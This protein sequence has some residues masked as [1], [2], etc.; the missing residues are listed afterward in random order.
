MLSSNNSN[1]Y[2]NSAGGGGGDDD[3]DAAWRGNNNYR[4]LADD[5][6]SRRI[7]EQGRTTG[8]RRDTDAADAAADVEEKEELDNSNRPRDTS[9]S[10]SSSSSRARMKIFD[11]NGR[12]WSQNRVRKRVS[13][14]QQKQQPPNATYKQYETIP[15]P[16][17]TS[18]IPFNER[19]GLPSPPL[20]STSIPKYY[21]NAYWN[22]QEEDDDKL[23]SSSPSSSSLLPEYDLTT[24][25]T[26]SSSSSSLFA[27]LAV[28]D[29]MSSSSSAI[30]GVLPVSELFYRSQ[31]YENNDGKEEEEE[32]DIEEK[33]TTAATSSK[34]NSN[35]SK[36]DKVESLSSSPSP[37]QPP[38]P[39]ASQFSGDVT[40]LRSGLGIAFNGDNDDTVAS[41]SSSSLSLPQSHLSEAVQRELTNM[42]NQEVEEQRRLDFWMQQQQQQQDG[43]ASKDRFYSSTPTTNNNNKPSNADL[44]KKGSG[45]T[46]PSSEEKGAVV[47]ND[48][49]KK[50]SS[51]SSSSRGRKSSKINLSSNNNNNNKSTYSDPPPP[52][53]HHHNHRTIVEQQ[54]KLV[55][56]G[57]EMLVG[58]EPINADPPQRSIELNYYR[59]HPKLWARA[60]TTNAPD[61][62]PLLH[63]HSA[64][65]V[66]KESIYLY[67]ENFV[68]STM[69]WG[70]CPEDLRVVVSEFE[71]RRRQPKNDGASNNNS[72]T[73]DVEAVELRD[74]LL[75]TTSAVSISDND[76]QALRQTII[77]SSSVSFKANHHHSES[78]K[79]AVASDDDNDDDD[80]GS[81]Y[82]SMTITSRELE[83]PKGFGSEKQYGSTKKWKEGR[84]P[85]HTRV[86]SCSDPSQELSRGDDDDDDDEDDNNN[87]NGRTFTLGGELKFSLGV[88]R[89]EIESDHDIKYD[90]FRRVLRDGINQSIHA[91]TIGFDVRIAELV[92]ED[93]VEEGE[94]VEAKSIDIVV[95]FHLLPREAMIGM[96]D[97]RKAAKKVNDAL[98][99][100]MEDGTLVM[101]LARAAR[102]ERGWSTKRRNRIME[103]FLLENENVNDETFRNENEDE[104]EDDNKKVIDY[105]KN[106]D[107][108][109]INDPEL[110]S[111]VFDDRYDGPFGME[112][113][114]LSAKD[115][116]WLGG[117]NGGVFF[118]YSESNIMNSPFKGKLGPYLVD[119]VVERARQNQPRVIAIGDVH[120][121]IDELKA[122]LRKCDYH[123][124]D[125]IVFLGDLV[126]KGPDSLSVVQM[127]REVG[128]LGVRG[129]HDF[130]V[131]RW[132]QAIK[133]GA[134]PPVIG[135]E[136]YYVASALTTADLK[137][138]YS[139]PWFINSSQLN[140]LFVHAGFV[141]GIR[142]AKQNPRLMMNMRSI[143]PDGTVTSKFFNNWPWARLWDGPQTILFGHDADRGLQQYDHAIGLDTGCVYGGKL[144][145]CILPEKRLV[146]VNAKREY[147]QYRRK[148]FD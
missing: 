32:E 54:R 106:P 46:S 112:D 116:I 59:K 138:M 36:Q 124:G 141:S 17:F 19:V 53:H 20:S 95:Q 78:G 23:L 132:H 115:D 12:R 31:Y 72:S 107:D 108:D 137:W 42:A 101:A 34:R 144:T 89:T 75:L 27:D 92:I 70:V 121:C 48:G 3:D 140:A 51:S 77:A 44:R 2:S 147:F 117:G 4:G 7:N 130:E 21:T 139:L 134:D 94:A 16:S 97:A 22:E 128:A 1:N 74:Q 45:F 37:Q 6:T 120:G 129:N 62:G 11:A 96:S 113:S 146:S 63:M 87:N 24:S 55:R 67:C 123:P 127:A 71:K 69:K 18:S 86:R 50:G 35:T 64:A 13:S 39:S 38:P 131:V 103:E 102:E 43:R 60:I 30:D 14:Q 56:R 110:D 105:V 82:Q 118:D 83:A 98:A 28:A 47:A 81:S 33:Y 41:S 68:S 91:S 40:K 143:L 10:S 79:E 119:A 84:R 126:C 135:S 90:A 93:V 100:A 114:V 145:A 76:M 125:V 61:F 8:R 29:I 99:V 65:K 148:H 109:E 26:S 66:G 49:T 58:G 80:V 57:M 142:L 52:P 111:L 122:L 25:S 73:G 88:S 5:D 15:I 104:D 85:L 136:H 133:S 9:S